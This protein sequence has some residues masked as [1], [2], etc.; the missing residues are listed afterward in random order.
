MAPTYRSP[1]TSASDNPAGLCYEKPMRLHTLNISP[2]KSGALN[3]V[4]HATCD[5]RGF[6]GDREWMVV[7]HNGEF[8]TQRTTPELGLLKVEV[9]GQTLTLTTDVDTVEAR[10]D[11]PTSTVK[12]WS[13]FV[14]AQHVD[15][16]VDLWLSS[17]L[18]REA[19]LVRLSGF[20]ATDGA[21]A[22]HPLSFA[23]G[24][25]YLIANTASLNDLNRRIPGPALGMDA[26]RANIVIEGAEPW[27]EDGW[28]RLTIGDAEFEVTTPCERC[29]VTTLDPTDP[30]RVRTDQ[31]PLRTLA[32]FRRHGG[33]VIFA[34]N[35]VCLT[36]GVVVR[37]GDPVTA[38]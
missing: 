19:R 38:R 11:G 24:Y 5:Q 17:F 3:P 10:P 26:F 9:D 6:S 23:D 12:V 1:L 29:K 13:S 21:W 2:L 32:T 4:D 18:N 14:E 15:P 34:V 25:P 22:D 8:L 28:K 33:G 37:V 16:A 31:E 36:P 35:A 20:R 7:D 30:R 27:A